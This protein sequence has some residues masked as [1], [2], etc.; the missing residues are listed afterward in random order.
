VEGES[1]LD[2]EWSTSALGPELAGWDWLS[3]SLADGRDLMVFR[4]RRRDGSAAPESRATLI[5]ADG[6][7]TLLAP[8]RYRF[9]G[10]GTWQSPGGARYPAGFHLEIPEERLGLEVTPL[11]PDQELRLGFR[12]WEGAVSAVG[13]RGDAALAGRGYLELTGYAR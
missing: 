12:Y 4:L 9:E 5:A 6:S 1:W 3:L 7:V 10:T 2:R 8:D 11:L 13:R